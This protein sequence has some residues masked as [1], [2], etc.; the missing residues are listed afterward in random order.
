[1]I[2]INLGTTGTALLISGNVIQWNNTF[3]QTGQAEIHVNSATGCIAC[4]A[5]NNWIEAPQPNDGALN[6][7][8]SASSSQ[9][10][11]F[12]YNNFNGGSH[13]TLV[14]GSANHKITNAQV[15]Y[16]NGFL[17]PTGNFDNNVTGAAPGISGGG[18]LSTG[19]TSFVGTIT[20]AAATGNVLTPGFT[21][22]N[23][24]VGV[25]QDDTT[26]G[27]VKVTAQNTTTITFS[28]TVSDTVEYSVSCR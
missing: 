12:V 18:S 22:P 9:G 3:G 7:T 14:I 25:F 5:Q 2:L 6:V 27:G 10:I 4:T 24:V 11:S 17:A 15:A 13:N 23:V 26:A 28:A 21:C 8:T 20:A 16:N 1:G 19:S